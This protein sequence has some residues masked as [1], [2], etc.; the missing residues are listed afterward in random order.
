MQQSKLESLI[1]TVLNTLSGYVV[2]YLAW[3]FIVGPAL[4]KGHNMSEAFWTTNFFTVLSIAR[5]YL[6]RR[7]F[8][9]GIHK[10]VVAW[11]RKFYA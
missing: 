6:W 5:S 2:S 11:V 10:M 3:I 1:E 7:F 9:N 4:G 8:N